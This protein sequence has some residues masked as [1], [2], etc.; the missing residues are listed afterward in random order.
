MMVLDDFGIPTKSEVQHL[1]E[2]ISKYNYADNQP[3]QQQPAP[4]ERAYA[5]P[6]QQAY[7]QQT[8]SV[9]VVQAPAPAPTVIQQQAPAPMASQ[10]PP[11][12]VQRPQV[13][14]GYPPPPVAYPYPPIAYRGYYPAY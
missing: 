2:M 13:I 4:I 14:Y 12:V 5:P 3:A 7:P 9:V 6:I 10:Q 1:P 8:P 11:I